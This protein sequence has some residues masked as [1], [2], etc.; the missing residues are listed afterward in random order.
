[1]R[2]TLGLRVVQLEIKADWQGENK[3]VKRIYNIMGDEARVY[4]GRRR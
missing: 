2:Q 3:N 4:L 1:M